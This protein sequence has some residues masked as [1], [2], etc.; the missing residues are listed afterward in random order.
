MDDYTPTAVEVRDAWVT[1]ELN[2][3]RNIT[4]T[5][6]IADFNRWLASVRADA[7]DEGRKS[8]INDGPDGSVLV[9]WG[10]K[11]NPYRSEKQ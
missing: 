6:D 10:G 3:A 11:P 8:A 1:S 2:S 5:E 9:S 4:S 7:W